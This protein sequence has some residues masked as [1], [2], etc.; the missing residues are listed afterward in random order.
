[1][2]ILFF[3]PYF[4]Q[5]RG[6]TTT[7]KRIVQSLCELNVQVTVYSYLENELWTDN[8]AEYDL[9]HI[10]HATRFA[11]W[12]QKHGVLLT[13]PYL[14]TMGG[15][16]INVDLS[17][18]LDPTVYQLL[19]RASYITVF[20]EDAK[21]KVRRLLP[22]WERKTHVISQTPWMS[23]SLN[24]QVAFN[25]PL[26]LLPAG[27]RPVK[28]VLHPLSALDQLTSDYP[29]LK[30][31]IIGAN[32]EDQ[33]YQQIQHTGLTRPW[34][35]YEGVIP[36][37]EM[38]KWYSQYNI[39]VNTSI[40]EGQSLALMEAMAIGKPVLA[41]RN[42][43]NT[44]LIQHG[45]TGWLYETMDEFISSIHVIMTN[46]SLRQQVID[47]AQ[48]SMLVSPIEEAKKYHHLYQLTIRS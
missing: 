39:V 44:S 36:F 10:L 30:Y 37:H 38:P 20:T 47:N 18:N 1:M 32:L 25:T 4:S 3:T 12:A 40:S 2:R 14:I 16:D 15:T 23:Q 27:L 22:S 41:R 8:F 11:I 31:T 26:L 45:L 46:S 42:E 24:A 35:T 34:L 5:S 6:N 19:D 21:Q 29:S 28:D 13:K 43:A 17:E 48:K 9:I 7:A 33:V